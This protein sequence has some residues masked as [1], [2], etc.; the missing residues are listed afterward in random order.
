MLPWLSG[1]EIGCRSLETSPNICLFSLKRR[2]EEGEKKNQLLQ[3][4]SA[5]GGIRKVFLV[6]QSS[7]YHN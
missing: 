5:K 4:E 7:D 2:D 3:L 1:H 6:A